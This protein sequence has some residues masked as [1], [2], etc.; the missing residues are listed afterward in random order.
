MVDAID[1]MATPRQLRLIAALSSKL[2]IPEPIA[3]GFGEAGRMIRELE[4]EV[5]WRQSQQN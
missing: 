5:V 3:K 2:H 4:A 1:G